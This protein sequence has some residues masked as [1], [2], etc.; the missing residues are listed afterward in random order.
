M[1]PPQSVKIEIAD[2]HYQF[3]YATTIQSLPEI[4]VYECREKGHRINWQ[5]QNRGQPRLSWKIDE[6]GVAWFFDYTSLLWRVIEWDS[7]VTSFLNHCQ[8][9][10]GELSIQFWGQ[11][12][13]IGHLYYQRYHYLDMDKSYLNL[14]RSILCD[15]DCYRIVGNIAIDHNI[16][17]RAEFEFSY[18]GQSLQP[19]LI[20]LHRRRS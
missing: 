9:A 15:Y 19:L 7:K 8:L 20:K 14:G 18:D 17:C 3:N 10:G 5:A 16:Y 11:Q 13:V 4:D 1:E 12:V 6:N 2:Q